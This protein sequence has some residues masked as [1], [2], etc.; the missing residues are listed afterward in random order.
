V[1]E[2][3][4]ETKLKI[5]NALEHFSKVN[6]KIIMVAYKEINNV[7][8]KWSQVE[9][10]LVLIAIIGIKDLIRDGVRSTVE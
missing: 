3:D 4:F 5:D 9:K 1:E 10:N 8:S 6:Q 2:I 7:P